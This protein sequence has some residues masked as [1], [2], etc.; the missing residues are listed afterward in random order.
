MNEW[1]YDP[2]VWWNIEFVSRIV[3]LVARAI[4]DIAKIIAL[5]LEH[6]NL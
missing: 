5:C 4:G 2:N 3:E 6:N 1:I